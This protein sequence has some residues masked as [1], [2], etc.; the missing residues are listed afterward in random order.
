MLLIPIP[1][2]FIII[3]IVAIV[4]G[5][6]PLLLAGWLVEGGIDTIK[7]KIVFFLALIAEIILIF[8]LFD[9]NIGTGNKQ[10]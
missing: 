10:K 5:I 4:L 6:I 3:I 2:W 7:G 1:R 8:F 9:F